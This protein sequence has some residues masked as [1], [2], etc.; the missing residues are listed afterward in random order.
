MISDSL[1]AYSL[2]QTGHGDFT[3]DDLLTFLE[4][5]ASLID[6]L[7]NLL[8]PASGESYRTTTVNRHIARRYDPESSLLEI[9]LDFNY[10]RHSFSLFGIAVSQLK[11]SED[12]APGFLDFWRAALE[13]ARSLAE[14]TAHILWARSLGSELNNAIASLSRLRGDYLET[15]LT[16]L[17]TDPAT[18]RRE[19]VFELI[20]FF[21]LAGEA[22]QTALMELATAHSVT[23]AVPAIRMLGHFRIEQSNALLSMLASDRRSAIRDAAA[24]ALNDLT[25]ASSTEGLSL[26]DLPPM[27]PASAP[28]AAPSDRYFFGPKGTILV[29]TRLGGDDDDWSF[30]TVMTCHPDG[31]RDVAMG[32][33]SFDLLRSVA[34]RLAGI[35]PASPKERVVG[36]GEAKIIDFKTGEVTSIDLGTDVG[37]EQQDGNDGN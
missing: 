31:T 16:R 12:Q 5:V 1:D 26:E 33:G 25:S 37:A 8:V 3:D 20:R 24:V 6:M 21:G 10:L 23:T 13:V 22:T 19:L 11:Q 36:M 30:S 28:E 29:M 14:F 7:L 18:A 2:R 35:L 4:T 34:G 9:T 17:L 32:E 15:F 27:R